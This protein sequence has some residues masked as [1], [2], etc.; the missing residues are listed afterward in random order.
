MIPASFSRTFHCN[1]M[2]SDSIYTRSDIP[3]SKNSPFS[4]S[5]LPTPSPGNILARDKAPLRERLLQMPLRHALRHVASDAQRQND[6]KMAT[7]STMATGVGSTT[8][9]DSGT[10]TTALPTPSGRPGVLGCPPVLLWSATGCTRC[11]VLGLG[12]LIYQLA[13]FPTSFVTPA[14]LLNYLD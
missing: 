7:A 11:A 10:I 12:P 13:G 14:T 1:S 3:T 8:A 9:S 2:T 5:Y 4:N 6:E